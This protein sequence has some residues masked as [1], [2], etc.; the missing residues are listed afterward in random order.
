MGAQT[1]CFK[2]LG[3]DSQPLSRLRS[4]QCE[5]IYRSSSS[6]REQPRT[7]AISDSTKVCQPRRP[8]EKGSGAKGGDRVKREKEA[9]AQQ[10]RCISKDLPHWTWS[11]FRHVFLSSRSSR[12][13]S[14]SLPLAPYYKTD[15]AGGKEALKH[16]VTK[17]S[18]HSGSQ[19]SITAFVFSPLRTNQK[20]SSLKLLDQGR[21]RA[22]F[23]LL[24]MLRSHDPRVLI[25]LS[26]STSL[27]L[28]L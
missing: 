25:A 23:Y 9:I 18:W 2:L 27:H 15:P 1:T 4:R 24:S 20:A 28:A 21:Q 3:V 16:H 7:C 13:Q 14:A 8:P 12:R 17:W 26:H 19:L 10:C 5:I 22:T 11:D 6:H